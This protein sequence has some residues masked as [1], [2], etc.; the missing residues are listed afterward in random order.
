MKL[1]WFKLFLRGKLLTMIQSSHTATNLE[2]LHKAQ[3]QAQ[4]IQDNVLLREIEC[5]YQFIAI[6]RDRDAA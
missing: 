6:K 5:N 3:Q 1:N 4:A 2:V